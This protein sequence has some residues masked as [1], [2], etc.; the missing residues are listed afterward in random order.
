MGESYWFFMPT[1]WERQPE[2][3]RATC[4]EMGLGCGNNLYSSRAKVKI[5]MGPFL[6]SS[7]TPSGP[8]WNWSPEAYCL[9]GSEVL[10]SRPESFLK[11]TVPSCRKGE[12]VNYVLSPSPWPADHLLSQLLGRKAWSPRV[13]NKSTSPNPVNFQ[14]FSCPVL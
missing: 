11:I 4:L 12:E 7:F 14:F 8:K 13:Q 10:D 3:S 9:V 1:S 2:T 5:W 6:S